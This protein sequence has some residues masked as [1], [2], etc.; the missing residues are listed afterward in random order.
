MQQVEAG[1]ID[2]VVVT[3][4]DMQGRLMGKR[5]DAEFFLEELD[6]LRPARHRVR[7]PRWDDVAVAGLQPVL[8]VAVVM[9]A[10]PALEDIDEEE[11]ELG[12]LVLGDRRL[13]ARHTFDHMRVVRAAGGLLDAEL[14]VEELRP[15]RAVVRLERLEDRVLEVL[16]EQRLPELGLLHGGPPDRFDGDRAILHRA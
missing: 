8:A 9:E 15:R 10:H 7:Q 5:V 4:T 6:V 1:R 14:P 13:R 3:F 16:D 12:V 2:T 11:V